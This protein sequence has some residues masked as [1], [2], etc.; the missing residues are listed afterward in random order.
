LNRVAETCWFSH[1]VS[2]PDLDGSVIRHLQPTRPAGP[3]LISSYPDWWRLD[4]A[5]SY[6]EP[7]FAIGYT[8]APWISPMPAN[9]MAARIEMRVLDSG[10][11]NR[12][13]IPWTDGE[14]PTSIGY[15]TQFGDMSKRVVMTRTEGVL[16]MTGKTR[17]S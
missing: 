13:T 1:I 14:D 7:R 8:G 16:G 9:E 12:F 5:A 4:N 2:A 15:V 17:S 3:Y 10:G 11:T 6:R